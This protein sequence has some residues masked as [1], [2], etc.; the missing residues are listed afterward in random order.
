[1]TAYQLPV[2][3]R[4]TADEVEPGMT[5]AAKIDDLVRIGVA[6]E[7]REG[8]WLTPEGHWIGESAHGYDLLAEAPKPPVKLPQDKG[9]VIRCR[10]HGGRQEIAHRFG[11]FFGTWYV[12]GNEELFHDEGI[13]ARMNSDGFEVAVWTK[14]E[15]EA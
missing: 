4:L 8:G 11:K 2:L 9:A 14:P 12:D 6:S 5:I 1:M 10:D 3:R 13:L 7:E 15:E